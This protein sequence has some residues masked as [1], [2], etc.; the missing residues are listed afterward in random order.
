MLRDPG[1]QTVLRRFLGSQ[2]KALHLQMSAVTR[3]PQGSSSAAALAAAIVPRAIVFPCE[4]ATT[5]LALQ[6]CQVSLTYDARIQTIDAMLL[7]VQLPLMM[8]YGATAKDEVAAQQQQTLADAI[9]ADKKVSVS[10]T[11]TANGIVGKITEACP[12][13]MND[14]LKS[15]L[16]EVTAA[17]LSS[18]T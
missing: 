8:L 7:R 1:I 5:K 16:F 13:A 9:T 2:L 3:P 12:E 17:F 14:Q 11:A 15:L 6:L 10:I 18:K 4:D